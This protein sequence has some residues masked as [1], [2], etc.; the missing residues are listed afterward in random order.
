MNQSDKLKKYTECLND[1]MDYFILAD[2][3]VLSQFKLNNYL[4]DNLI[5]EFTTNS[6]GDCAV[7]QGVIIPLRGIEN[8]PYT[9]YF[10][11]S[12][13]SVFSKFKSSVQHL[14]KGYVMKVES[15]KVYLF[16][17]PALADW[18]ENSKFVKSNKPF[19]DLGNGWYNIEI[20]GGETLQNTGWEPTIEFLFKRATRQPAYNADFNYLYKISSR[21]YE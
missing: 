16:T 19:Y 4:S 7:E 20:T 14:Q 15:G 12:P 1:L 18:P 5:H 3:E 13:S 11:N 9:V 8:F 2:I 17:M 6:S 21:E 10:N